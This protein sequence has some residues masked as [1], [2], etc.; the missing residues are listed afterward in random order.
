M[1]C[2]SE[3]EQ[4]KIASIYTQNYGVIK[5][6]DIYLIK[7]GYITNHS[8]KVKATTLSK[9]FVKYYQKDKQTTSSSD[10]GIYISDLRFDMFDWKY[11][12]NNY[13]VSCLLAL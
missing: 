5:P 9:Y 11:K 6:L 4:L 12:Y 3:K 7:D 10:D 1:G 13:S 8:E 2:K